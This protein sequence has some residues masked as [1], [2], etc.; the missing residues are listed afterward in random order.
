[1]ALAPAYHMAA[2]CPR[3]QRAAAGAQGAVPQRHPHP[4]R[5][6]AQARGAAPGRADGRCPRPVPGE[7]HP[8]GL[9]ARTTG[10]PPSGTFAAVASGIAGGRLRRSS[11][12]A[13][14]TRSTST[15]SCWPGGPG[16]C[17]T[18]PARNTPTRCCASRSGSAAS[19]SR[20]RPDAGRPRTLL[21]KLLDQY[22]LA[23]KKLG[24]RAADDAWVESSAEVIY[25]G[26][27]RSR[28]RTRWPRPWP[29]GSRPDAIGEAIVAG[30]Q[31]AGA[32]RPRPAARRTGR[33]ARSGSVHGDSV[34]RPRLGRGQRL[35]EHRPREQPA[36]HGRQPDRRRRTTRPASTAGSSRS[37]TRWPSTWRR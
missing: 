21:P 25:G 11:S 14:R 6:R 26:G 27:P 15:A 2:S 29:R 20:T 10:P 13:S 33:Q 36:E 24:T 18:S 30:G 31:P 22:K 7:A 28:R 3:P 9:T 23:G 5:G 8:R 1:M 32:A 17:S 12:T 19:R 34:G 37:R 35:A 16:P 4:G